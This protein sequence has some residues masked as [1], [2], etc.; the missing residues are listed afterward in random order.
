M[1]PEW[2]EMIE[3]HADLLT[4]DPVSRYAR[5]LLEGDPEEVNQ[6]KS[7]LEIQD[8]SWLMH[9][10]I[11]AQIAAATR[12]SDV[13]FGSR[14]NALLRLLE[15]HPLLE[16]AGLALILDRYAAIRLR[17]PNTVLRD[18]AVSSWGNPTFRRHSP[19]WSRVS[20]SAKEMIAKWAKLDIIKE[21]FEIL[22]EDRLTDQR[23]LKFWQR[24]HEQID[25]MYFALGST[26]LNAQ[27][28]DAKRVRTKMGEHL[29]VLKRGGSPSNN[30]FI[31]LMG[32]IVV[33]E[34][35]LKGNAC[36]FYKKEGLP[37]SLR[38]EVS[39]DGEG[40]RSP[41]HLERLIH[42][43]SSFQTWEDKFEAAL[44]ARDI[45]TRARA[46]PRSQ[47]PRVAAPDLQ[48]T[49]DAGSSNNFSRRA[50][51][52]FVREHQLV[53]ADNTDRGGNVWVISPAQS[54]PIANVL[55]SWG[56]SYS[57]KRQSWWRKDWT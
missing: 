57:D 24:Y 30:A 49:S 35:G 3:D 27:D 32:E 43:D 44:Q 4:E 10:L 47:A 42:K 33:V 12:E 9:R 28:A 39:G 31:M 52:A 23:R 48:E 18:R 21:F 53:V 37:F 45:R 14:T 20:E 15:K 55:R 51:E 26:A 46:S 25:G 22:S 36:F 5:K 13:S 19:Q 17:E 29:L 11:L 7:K 8:G 6:I 38:Y 34:F 41:N 56:F 50:L 2:A 54:G 16:N 1:Q 40:L